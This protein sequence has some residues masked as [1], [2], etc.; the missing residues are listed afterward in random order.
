MTRGHKPSHSGE[1][2]ELG[3]PEAALWG[4]DFKLFIKKQ[5][6]QKES[7]ALSPFLPKRLRQRNLLQ[8]GASA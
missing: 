6:T 7:L 5:E 4:T 3:H 8:E 2:N 1:G